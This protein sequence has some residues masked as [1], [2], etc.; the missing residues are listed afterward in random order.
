[1]L[2][3]DYLWI[4]DELQPHELEDLFPTS[5]VTFIIISPNIDQ[6][7]SNF[8][9]YMQPWIE[10]Y[11][12][13][14]ERPEFQAHTSK[15]IEYIYGEMKYH[16]HPE[17]MELLIAILI[18][19]TKYEDCFIHLFDSLEIEPVL[20]ICHETLAEELNDVTTARNRVWIHDDGCVVLNKRNQFEDYLPLHSAVLQIFDGDYTPN[21]VLTTE[22]KE[23][24][25][26]IRG[27][28]HVHDVTLKLPVPIAK[29]VSNDTMFAAK[30]LEGLSKLDEVKPLEFDE[31]VEIKTAMNSMNLGVMLGIALANGGEQHLSGIYL[32]GLQHFYQGKPD[33]KIPD[34]IKQSSRDVLQDELISIGIINSKVSE[35][36]EL[37]EILSS[38]SESMDDEEK[39]AKNL[40]A[41]FDMNNLEETLNLDEEQVDDD[42]DDESDFSDDELNEFRWKYHDI[43]SGWI[44]KEFVAS[45]YQEFKHSILKLTSKFKDEFKNTEFDDFPE[46]MES[47]IILEMNSKN[48]DTDKIYND[49]SDYQSDTN[50]IHGD[51]AYGEFIKLRRK[52]RQDEDVVGHQQDEDEEEDEEWEDVN[53]DN[54]N[55]NDAYDG[56]AYDNDLMN[57]DDNFEE[58]LETKPQIEVID[59][60]SQNVLDTRLTKDEVERLTRS[61]H[62]LRTSEDESLESSLK[63]K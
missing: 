6:T 48:N 31:G 46:F 13:S 36:L 30:A 60:D 9:K 16:G 56:D 18:N 35:D 59:E 38:L 21:E 12:W 14:Y 50:E 5:T 40:K 1:M 19:F 7:L 24:C 53:D 43:T 22:I 33:P 57:D 47:E 51:M 28:S 15:S 37:V 52:M 17:D 49:D 39:Y 61:L 34:T 3:V 23:K 42:D 20:V 58:N 8:I 10:L 62:T 44:P 41:L 25:S 32:S 54:D 29:L 2:Q 11:P 63:K 26:L 55:D 4:D 27:L 45:K